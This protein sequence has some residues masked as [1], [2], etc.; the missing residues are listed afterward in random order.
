M[1]LFLAAELEPGK[2]AGGTAPPSTASP[3]T[4]RAYRLR[5]GVEVGSKICLR[6]LM[7]VTTPRRHPPK[8]VSALNT[9]LLAF[10]ACLNPK[11]SRSWLP[12]RFSPLRP[13]SWSFRLPEPP[14]ARRKSLDTITPIRQFYV[15]GFSYPIARSVQTLR[16]T[17]FSIHDLKRSQKVHETGFS[18]REPERRA[19]GYSIARAA[20]KAA[21]PWVLCRLRCLRRL[22]RLFRL[23]CLSYPRCPPASA[24]SRSSTSFMAAMAHLLRRRRARSRGEVL[25]LHARPKHHL[26]KPGYPDASPPTWT[27]IHLRTRPQSPA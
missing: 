21:A 20:R 9:P 2:S 5:L 27:A 13:V 4:T 22:R 18:S 8:P 24:S 26:H 15:R 7:V 1:W 14:A 11:G 23:R 25:H 10:S 17:R 12:R 3:P 6:R 16:I 19:W